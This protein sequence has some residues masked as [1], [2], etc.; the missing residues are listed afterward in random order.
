MK[1]LYPVKTTYSRFFLAMIVVGMHVSNL[2]GQ[3][4]V[5]NSDFTGG[6]SSGWSTSSSIE[7][8]PQTIYG[9]PS[10][11]V[12]VSEIDVE[13]TLNQQVCILP[14]LS[15]TL[16]YQVTRRPQ[17]STPSA[18]GIKLLV[19]GVSSAV[20]YINSNQ[21]YTNT[22]WSVQTKTFTFTVP[23]N[24]TD[25]KVNIQFQPRNNNSTFGVLV[26]DI[27]LAPAGTDPLSIMGPVTS[28]VATPNNFFVENSPAGTSYNWSFSDDAS[29]AT[30]TSA[31]PTGITW[32]SLGTKDV[33]VSVSN[34]ACTMATYT[35]SV[36]ISAILPV[37]WTG[38]T[39]TIRGGD[40][41]LAWNT[42]GESNGNYFTVLRSVDGTRFDSIG[43]VG[44]A[45]VSHNYQFT[46]PA[47]PGGDIYYRI[48]YVRLDGT[49]LYSRVIVLHNS[50]ALDGTGMRLFP[51]P[52]ISTLNYAIESEEPTRV[53]ILVYNPAGV[54]LYARQAQLSVGVNQGVIGIDDLKR[55]SYFLK[56]VDAR[57]DLRGVRTFIKN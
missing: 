42:T 46:D 36:A 13:R 55:G 53:S 34:G 12:Y 37:Q 54:L 23:S 4:L 9:G 31:A 29:R 11:S 40:A 41:F 26:W 17:S 27:E 14:G 19:T 39:G 20:N 24:A 44:P 1:K 7:I 21:S 2:Q 47:T 33:S 28:G 25:K 49:A 15:Y 32:S 5:V 30:S 52:A 50:S 8:N 6:S 48:C 18:P 22:T 3:N 16:T 38:F 56:I 35:K 51:N 45:G 10:S 43:V 57:G